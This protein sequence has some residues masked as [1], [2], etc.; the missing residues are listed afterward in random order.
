MMKEIKK[1]SSTE[2]SFVHRESFRFLSEREEEKRIPNNYF[3]FS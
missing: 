1:S 2:A 3:N